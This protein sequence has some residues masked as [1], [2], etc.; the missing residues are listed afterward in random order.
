M[1]AFR[2]PIFARSILV[3]VDWQSQGAVVWNIQPLDR[4]NQVQIALR[5]GGSDGRGIEIFPAY[6]WIWDDDS[7]LVLQANA[8]QAHFGVRPCDVQPP[9]PAAE[10]I[11]SRLGQIRPN[12]RLVPIEPAPKLQEMLERQ[13]RQTE[14]SF[15]QHGLRQS[16]RPDAA[17]A[18][19]SYD[20]ARPRRPVGRL[21]EIL[22]SRLEH[23]PQEPGMGSPGD[24]ADF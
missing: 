9:M 15:A 6:N 24:S 12:A 1:S 16:V 11:K 10:S 22:R 13:A 7:A 21:R 20:L 14:Q 3:P 5:A 17:R 8:M 23:L 19:L 4:C 2:R 18:R